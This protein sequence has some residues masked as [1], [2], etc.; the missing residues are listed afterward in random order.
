[1]FCDVISC[2]VCV[3]GRGVGR[4]RVRLIEAVGPV[5]VFD[6]GAGGFA[7]SAGE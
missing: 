7:C 3:V 1:M 5:Y 6:L 2:V 4:E